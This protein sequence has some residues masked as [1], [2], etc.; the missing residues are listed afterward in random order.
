[1]RIGGKVAACAITGAAAATDGPFGD[2]VRTSRRSDTELL[3]LFERL[4]SK[5]PSGLV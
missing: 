5:V 1:M 4:E 2:I 3:A